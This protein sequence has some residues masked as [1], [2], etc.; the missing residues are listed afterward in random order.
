MLSVVPV[1][2]LALTAA[3]IVLAGNHVLLGRL[4]AEI[5]AR[6]PAGLAGTVDDAIRGAI[7]A[8]ATVGVLGLV[9]AL[10]SGVGWMR[11]LRDALTEQWGLAKPKLP[12]VSTAVKDL[13][14]LAGLGIGI[15]VSFALTAVGGALLSHGIGSGWSRG[16]SLVGTGLLAVAVNWLL[17]IWVIA[18]LPRHPVSARRA[19]RGALLAAVGLE[20]LKQLAS[21]LLTRTA[22]SP[23]GAVFGPMIG[24]LLFADLAARV[25]L[26]ATAW[27]VTAG[28]RPPA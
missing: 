22:H 12:V 3:A 4:Q 16:L 28:P 25:L 1:L 6:V 13:V 18:R 21:L 26:F 5:A 17:F 14:A 24:L 10:Y 23:T 2:M 11:H 15:A 19:M 8:R 20:A 27:T 7:A 9:I